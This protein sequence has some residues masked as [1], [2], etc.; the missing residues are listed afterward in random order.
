MLCPYCGHPVDLHDSHDREI[1]FTNVVSHVCHLNGELTRLR[2]ALEES[3]AML[4]CSPEGQKMREQGA[5]PPM[6]GPMPI[7][8]QG[9]IV[10][11]PNTRPRPLDIRPGV[12]LRDPSYGCEECIPMG[13]CERHP[14]SARTY[15]R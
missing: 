11:D 2:A 3:D 10:S 8:T 5:N 12:V 13:Y 6:V 4:A 7:G 14:A 15:Y 9:A 1:C